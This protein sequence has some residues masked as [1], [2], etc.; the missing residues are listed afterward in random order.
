MC[1]S[2]ENTIEYAV[3]MTQRDTVTEDYILQGRVGGVRA[4]CKHAAMRN[5]RA[6]LAKA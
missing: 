4:R 2:L 3:A 5:G 1:A 6:G